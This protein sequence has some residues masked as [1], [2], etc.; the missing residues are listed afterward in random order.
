MT[1]KSERDFSYSREKL[2]REQ[3]V[4]MN[5]LEDFRVN[6]LKDIIKVLSDKSAQPDKK[7]MKSYE[8]REA[9]NI[10]QGTLQNLRNNGHLPYTK[11]GGLIF[12]EYKDVVNMV[13]KNRVEMPSRLVK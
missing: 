6:L 4:T 10:S 1:L 11:V 2:Y 5:D 12:Y 7:W 9:L 8:V 3:I 13:G